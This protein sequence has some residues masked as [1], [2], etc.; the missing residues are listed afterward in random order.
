ME[1]KN[2]F[3]IVKQMDNYGVLTFDFEMEMVVPKNLTNEIYDEMFLIQVWSII[4]NSYVRGRFAPKRQLESDDEEFQEA[5]NLMF[6]PEV[7]EHTSRKIKIKVNFE[8]SDFV[9]QT[10]FGNDQVQIK[11]KSVEHLIIKETGRSIDFS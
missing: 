5:E 4:D 3:M 2:K 10:S 7:L 9:S 6:R 1:K 8:N 11:L